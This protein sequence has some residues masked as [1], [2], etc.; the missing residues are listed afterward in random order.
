MFRHILLNYVIC[1]SQMG[2]DGTGP[3]RASTIIKTNALN[4]KVNQVLGSI[5]DKS[6]VFEWIPSHINIIGNEL[7]D[8]AAKKA[9]DFFFLFFLDCLLI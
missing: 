3:L 8:K 7:A 6:I 5:Q 1:T 2:Y 9:T 4:I